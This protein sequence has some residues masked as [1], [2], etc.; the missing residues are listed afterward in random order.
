MIRFGEDVCD[1]LDSALRRE[2]LESAGIVR[3]RTIPVDTYGLSESVPELAG[4]FV[5]CEIGWPVN[6]A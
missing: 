1:N 3:S 5:Q 2:W 6:G 4:L